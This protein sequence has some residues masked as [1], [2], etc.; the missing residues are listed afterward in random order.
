M[1][2]WVD[3]FARSK[4]CPY[5]EFGSGMKV[6]LANSVHDSGERVCRRGKLCDGEL[7]SR[8]F[9]GQNLDWTFR[10]DAGCYSML[11]DATVGMPRMN[12]RKLA[13]V[14]PK[15]LTMCLWR[16]FCSNIIFAS[17]DK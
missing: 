7:V 17:G 2:G 9:G 12:E 3:P 13:H 5:E 16:P 15:R 14:L 6:W 10:V 1:K 8:C 4:Y 11:A